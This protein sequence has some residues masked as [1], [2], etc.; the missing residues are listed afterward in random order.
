M[1]SGIPKVAGKNHAIFRN[2]K[3]A[4]RRERTNIRR[5]AGL[6]GT[7]SGIRGYGKRD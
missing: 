7:G 5:E 2:Q 6:K 4:K 3:I 1:G